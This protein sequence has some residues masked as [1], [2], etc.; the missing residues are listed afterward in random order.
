[1]ITAQRRRMHLRSAAGLPRGGP[2]RA[3]RRA[4]S[5]SGPAARTSTKW[6][7]VVQTVK[8]PREHVRIAMVGK[9][10]DL[11]D[12]LQEPARGDRP[13]R[14]R[15]RVQGRDRLRRLGEDRDRRAARRWWSAPTASSCPRASARAGSRARSRGALRA[16][17]E[18][19]VPRHLLRHADG[20]DRVRAQRVR[21]GR[22]QLQRGRRAHAAS[23]DR[24]DARAAHG[25][26]QGRHD[27]P[28]RLRLRLARGLAGVPAVRQAEDHRAPPPSLR[29]QQRLPRAAARRPGSSSAAS[30]DESSWW[31]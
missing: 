11:V 18:D 6:A 1:M 26:P 28:G 19:A 22:R 21:P 27:A 29:G 25:D 17:G 4:S 14:H 8:N 13:R 9:Y 15:Q 20:G 5:T 2:R 10:V 23:G 31:R 12:S 24:P 16:R 3:R 7:K 30:P